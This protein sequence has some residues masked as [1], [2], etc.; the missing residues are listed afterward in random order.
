MPEWPKGTDCNPV[1]I[2]S[3]NL[4]LRSVLYLK[5]ADERSQHGCIRN[6]IIVYL[7]DLSWTNLGDSDHGKWNIFG[8]GRSSSGGSNLD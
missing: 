4:L 6:S 8:M 3:S 2:S 1:N 5:Y 7:V